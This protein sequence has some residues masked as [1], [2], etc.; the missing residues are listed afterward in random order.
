MD[1]QRAE[2]TNYSPKGPF[3]SG[4]HDFTHSLRFSKFDRFELLMS[5]YAK[6]FD[7]FSRIGD[8]LRFPN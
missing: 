6:W 8:S 7:R 4:P 1:S 5:L 2:P 3:L